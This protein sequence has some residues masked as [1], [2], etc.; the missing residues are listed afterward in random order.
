MSVLLYFLG[1]RVPLDDPKLNKFVHNISDTIDFLHNSPVA[2]YPVLRHV[3]PQWS[4]WNK[5]K[6]IMCNFFDFL[7]SHIRDHQ[8]DFENRKE[9]IKEDP[10]DFIDAYLAKIDESTSESSF[11]KYGVQ[12]L[13]SKFFVF[14]LLI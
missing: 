4:G 10:N 1:V 7:N 14:C 11:R 9:E 5:T 12:S 8:I 13:K 2:S 6:N 3:F